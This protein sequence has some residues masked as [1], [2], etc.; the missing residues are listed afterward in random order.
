[1]SRRR[2]GSRAPGTGAPA[3]ENDTAPSPGVGPTAVAIVVVALALVPWIDHT[4]G[5]LHGGIRE[6]DSVWYPMPFAG[7][8]AQQAPVTGSPSSWPPWPSWRTPAARAL[9]SPWRRWPAAWRWE[10][11]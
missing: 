7:R 10:P 5:S 11:G 6:Y 9:R 3:A 4:L 8:F 2:A 1:A